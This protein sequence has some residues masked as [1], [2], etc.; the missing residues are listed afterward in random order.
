MGHK[1]K[2]A[3]WMAV[4]ALAGA[5]TTIQLQAV[6]R[7]NMSPL[8]L[9]ELQQLAAVFS[10]IKSDYVEPTDDKK[11]ITDAISGMVTGLDPHSA[12]YDKKAWKEFREGTS[13]SFVGVGIEITMED[14]LVKVVSPIEDSP[15]AAAGLATNDL[16][17]KIDDTPVKGLTIT[18]AVKR[19][20]GE[21][22]TTVRLQVLRRAEN[23]SF[24]VSITR[25]RIVTRSVKSK[26]LDNGYA[27]IRISQFQDRTVED[28]AA[29]LQE[30]A[31]ASPNMRGLVLDLRN[32]PGGLLDAAVAV[33]AVFLPNE[34]AVVS[35]NG[36]LEESRY[37]FKANPRYYWRRGGTDPLTKLDKATNGLFKRVPLVVLVNE[38]SASASEIVAGALQDYGR[39]TIMGN[40]TF[41]KGS[42]QTVRALGPD[43]GLKI[44]TAR[45]YTPK[46]RSIQAKG[47]VPD[48]LVDETAEGNLLA[49]LSTR[50]ADLNKHLENG[51]ED[52]AEAAKRDKA[53][54]AAQ[55]KLEARQRDNPGE[56]LLPEYGS[57]DDFRLKQA[58]N[59]LQGL[60]VV[61]SKTLKARETPSAE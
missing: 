1:L 53:R 20:R 35:T 26:T 39:A 30:L 47:I 50:E 5:L 4:G 27:W 34:S 29:R 40:Q 23:R 19:M 32:D 51:V 11:L 18:E 54:E 57:A 56:R 46:G 15:A 14:G 25:A 16:I 9:E 55:A 58:L 33:S 38:G 31:D 61:V 7:S 52:P 8:P 41:G 24:S 45:Y 60:P 12:Y 49:A 42:V 28:F 6:A 59:H 43:T 44:T 2:I 37:V 48:V 10:M 3:S 13:G 36:Q 21:P 22:G 17:T